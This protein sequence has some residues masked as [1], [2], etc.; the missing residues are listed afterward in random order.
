MGKKLLLTIGVPAL[1]FAAGAL[2]ALW[3]S[4]AW[5][6]FPLKYLFGR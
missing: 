3:V 6:Y 1:V 4:G 5:D 2:W